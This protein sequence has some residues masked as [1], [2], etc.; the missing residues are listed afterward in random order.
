MSL[1]KKIIFSIVLFTQI[2]PAQYAIAE[3]MAQ[4]NQAAGSTEETE[5]LVFG[6]SAPCRTVSIAAKVAGNVEYMPF[7][8]GDYVKSGEVVLKV[9]KT[10]YELQ[11]ALARTQVERAKIALEQADVEFKRLNELFKSNSAS[12]QMKDNALFAKLS[13]QANLNTADASLKI[14]ENMLKNAE[15]CAPMNGFVSVKHREPGDF[16][17]KAKPVYDIVDL[18]TIKANLKVPELLIAKIKKGDKIDISVDVYPGE[19]FSGEIYE[20][21][22]VGDALTHF[23]KV[24]ATIKN[25]EHKLKAGMFLKATIKTK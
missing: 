13:A 17:D 4:L 24:S 5:I 2:L 16:A 22:P 6:S 1:I 25:T 18:D 11:V 19:T 21:N 8:E 7:A 3:N 15:I 23:F 20:I 9:E 14:A 12:V 10:D